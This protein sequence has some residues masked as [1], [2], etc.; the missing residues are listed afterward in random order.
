MYEQAAGMRHSFEALLVD[1]TLD[2]ARFP[3]PCNTTTQ[4]CVSS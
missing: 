2:E 3:T 4:A 1:E